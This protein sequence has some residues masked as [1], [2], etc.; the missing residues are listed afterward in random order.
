MNDPLEGKQPFADRN[1]PE[2]RAEDI[3]R[4]ARELT[5]FKE[6]ACIAIFNRANFI[7]CVYGAPSEVATRIRQLSPDKEFVPIGIEALSEI[8]TSPSIGQETR[9]VGV[10]L[11]LENIPGL[12]KIDPN[13]LKVRH[14]LLSADIT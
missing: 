2:K 3:E 8:Y 14:A 5:A 4:F 13:K 7:C 12:R 11:A 9:E 1:T 6:A 10:T